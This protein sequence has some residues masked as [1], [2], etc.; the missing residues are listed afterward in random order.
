MKDTLY[1]FVYRLADIH[2]WIMRL[3]D[4]MEPG[5][6]DKELHFLV[7]G[8]A[9]M[10]LYALV[11]P[12]V[13]WLARRRLEWVISLVYTLTVVVVITFGI[14]VGQQ[15]TNTGTMEF[16]DIVYGLAGFLA[17]FA[18]YRVIVTVIRAI[19]RLFS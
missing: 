18:V 2:E 3:N 14:E 11:H 1:W 13:R 15:I 5:F 6:T 19:I 17:I 9:G 16:A 7:I 8:V 10:M 12:L 4:G